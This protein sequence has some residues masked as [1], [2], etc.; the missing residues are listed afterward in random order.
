MVNGLGVLGWGVGG[1]E[2]EAAMLGQPMSMLIPQVLGVRL[3]GEL[4][5]G[6]TATDLVLTVTQMLRGRGVVGMFVE[7][8][9]AGLAGLPIADRATIGNMSPEFGSTCAIFP[10]DAETLAYLEF[11]GRPPERIALVEAYAKEQGLWHDEHSE[12]PTF[13]DTIELDL[14]TVEPSLAGPKRPQDRVSLSAAKR[15][16]GRRSSTT[17]PATAS[18]PTR[19]TRPSPSP[20]PR[21]TRPPTAPR[22]REPGRRGASRPGGHGHASPQRQ[23]T[24]VTLDGESFELDHGHVVIAA[25]TSCT[26][27]SN[28]SV[29]IAAGILARN[30]VARGLQ[31]EALGQDIA[32]AGLEGRHRISRPGWPHRAARSA[33]L[34]PRR[35]RLHHLHRKLRSAAAGDLG[36]GQRGDL[37]VVSVLSGNRNF[38]GRINPDVKMNYLASPP[39]CVAYALAGHDG[40]RHRRARRS[41]SDEQGETVYLRDIWP[42][43][44]RSLRRSARRCRRTCSAAATREVFAGD[45]R[46][47]SLG[48]ARRASASPGTSTRPTCACRRTSRACP[49]E[50]APVSDIGD[51]RVLALLGDSVTTDHISPAGLHQARQP[52][53][54]Y[55]HGTG[56]RAARLQLVRLAPRQ[57]RGDDARDVREHP[58]AQPARARAPKAASP[59]TSPTV[60]RRADADLRR[61][62]A[63]QA[64]D[65]PWSCSAGKEYGSGSSRDWAAKG[66]RLLGVR[67]V[68]AE[69]F[70]RIHRSNLVG[71]G[72][73]P[74]Q[75]P[76]GERRSRWG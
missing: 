30:A 39:L 8:Y 69:S 41:A 25:I 18:R 63:L 27:T 3:H 36:G 21:R 2:A 55:L 5:E 7:F 31:L 4:P 22:P 76:D 67:A 20:I 52:R 49:A 45:E 54:Q 16:S 68:I 6:A 26:N 11:T 19:R 66:T 44:G 62:D 32:G 10:I 64:R 43:S 57:P 46:W 47:N 65:V 15:R 29:M 53:R 51:A 61:C 75:F 40:R 1:I 70:E 13:S 17:C 38:E 71:M 9:G 48:G 74:L 34:Q 42:P 59:A 35:L 14:G 50:P 56:R 33:R 12:E 73:L 24:P 72:V 23:L 58:P 37:A 60:R 28:P